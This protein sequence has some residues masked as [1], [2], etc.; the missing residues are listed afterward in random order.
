MTPRALSDISDLIIHHSAGPQT[1]TPL[2]IDQEHRNEGWAMIGYNYVVGADGTVY[3]G[4]PVDVV[5]SAAY[6][7]NT[8][9]INVCLL[10]NYQP[11]TDGYN[12]NPPSP[13]ISALK[14]FSIFLHQKYP[15]ISRTIG[16]RDIAPM[17]FPQDE[18][19]YSTACPGQSL[20]VLL[21]EIRSSTLAVLVHH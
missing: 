18:G 5:P 19:D 12:G 16:H 10:G 15:Q 8:E 20:Y 6:G 14:Q 21:K 2:A 17:F 4:R 9:S 1:Q 13:Q 11:G 3:A 7:R